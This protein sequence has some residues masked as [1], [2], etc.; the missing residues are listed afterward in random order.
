MSVSVFV[1]VNVPPQLGSSSVNVEPL[2]GVLEILLP[3]GTES[4][5]LVVD[6]RR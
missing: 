2:P 1:I 3:T 4:G 5:T 6:R